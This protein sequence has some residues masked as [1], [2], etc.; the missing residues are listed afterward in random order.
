MN[1]KRPL[2]IGGVGAAGLLLIYF[3]ILSLVN[4]FTHAITEFGRLWY[5]ILLL[6]FGFGTQLGLYVYIRQALKRKVKG[7]T[8]EVTAAGGISTGSMIACCA[9]H[10]TDILPLLGLAGAAVF[11]TQFQTPFILLGV[12]S[13]LVGITIM[14]N[15][16]QK[17]GLA[18]ANRVFLSLEQANMAAVRNA[19]IGVSVVI[20]GLSFTLA[21]FV[22]PESRSGAL[23]AGGEPFDLPARSSSENYVRVEVKP[24][25]FSVASP[26]TFQVAL[27]THQGSLDYDL[28]QISTLQCDRGITMEPVR[29]EGS[30]PGGHHRRGILVFPEFNHPV[31][32]MHL[33]I[34]GL[35][36]VP[37]RSFDWEIST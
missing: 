20:V 22:S 31:S 24:V 4:S 26:T 12:F 33:T 7:M 6:A 11:L 27:N 35:Y 10:V 18:G 34:K 14:L 9:H 8:A 1:R 15:L 13:N 3:G 21:A 32:S 2:I 30:P 5:W 37:E 19:A 36:D 17:H 28:T 29:W 16:I 25:E 23:A